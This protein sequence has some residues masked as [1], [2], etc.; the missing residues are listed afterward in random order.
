MAS[1]DQSYLFELDANFSPTILIRQLKLRL[2]CYKVTKA[3]KPLRMNDPVENVEESGEGENEGVPGDNFVDN[4]EIDELLTGLQVKRRL[5]AKFKWRRSKCSFYCPVS[6]KDG[7]IVQGRQDYA[8]TFLDK[9][10]MMADE[11]A[12]RQFLKNPR[13]YLKLPQPRAPCKLSIL[14]ASY[15]GKT[16]LSTVLAKKYN[17]HMID[18]NKLMEPLLNKAKEEILER[19]KID[20]AQTTIENIRINYKEKIEA[21][22]CTFYFIF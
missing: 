12:L 7:R 6:L 20:T 5:A 8:A 19:T 18:M 21:K 14:G 22:K 15:S 2:Q 1:M 13:P 9:V 10:Y 16:S 17:A 11:N 4:A 3:S